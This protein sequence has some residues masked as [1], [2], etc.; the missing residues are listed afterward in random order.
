MKK[1]KNFRLPNGAGSVYKLSGNRRNPY[2]A[3]FHCGYTDEGKP[4]RKYIGYYP[5]Y[6]EALHGL[7]MYKETP[8]DLTDKNINLYR[9]YKIFIQRKE[10]SVSL[11]TLRAYQSAFKHLEPIAD[12]PIRNI[13]TSD[14]QAIFDNTALKPQS[15]NIIRTLIN[16]L[17][18]IAAEMDVTNKN[19]VK[20]VDV[21][22]YQPS[23]KHKPF[24]E[25]E[26]RKLWNLAEKNS[27]AE[28]PLILCYTGLRPA[29]LLEIKKENV[30][31]EEGYLIG[32]KKTEAG[33]N[34]VIPLHPAIRPIIE[35]RYAESECYLIEYKGRHMIYKTFYDH[36][37]SFCEQNN[38]NHLP[39]DGRHTFITHSKKSGMDSL[40]LKRIVGHADKDLTEKV[41]THT[42][43]IQLIQAISAI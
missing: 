6:E 21:G 23:R 37:L 43:I 35:K 22:K 3:V 33:K 25:L 41:Y 32:G 26:L 13:R 12:L 29:E 28:L 40:I 27:F 30:F 20:F 2:T 34:R 16:Q 1:R 8:Y 24:T 18:E 42:D 9:L 10:K 15:K 31:L 39:H 7:E 4:I 14:L 5:T 11:S 17:Y 36:W 19:Y 38:L